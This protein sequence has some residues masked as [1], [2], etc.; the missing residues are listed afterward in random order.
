M[1]PY[2]PQTAARVWQRVQ[3]HNTQTP[4][5]S[6]NPES[7]LLGLIL[8]EWISASTY[9]Q[10]SRTL[11][12]R[13]GAVLQRLFREEQTHAACL[14]GIYTLVTGEKPLMKTPALPK[15]PPELTLRKCY[16]RE[17]QSLKEY[18]ARSSDAEYGP[19]FSRLAEQER[20]HCRAVLE[21]LG[22]MQKK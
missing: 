13:E 2:D 6:P 21:L 4:V 15:E 3:G 19:V 14:K 1:K 9:L 5:E 7:G 22:S 11:S 20:E 12:P 18:E 8:E 16:V 17:M 10:L